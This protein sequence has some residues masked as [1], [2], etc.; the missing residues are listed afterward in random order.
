MVSDRIT[1]KN[2]SAWNWLRRFNS[3]IICVISTQFVPVLEPSSKPLGIG[4]QTDVARDRSLGIIL[5][6][7][8]QIARR[9][10]S[11]IDFMNQLSFEPNGKAEE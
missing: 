9:S 7:T 2:N 1:E 4:R 11:W 8:Q 10:F 3:Q 5:S 6:E